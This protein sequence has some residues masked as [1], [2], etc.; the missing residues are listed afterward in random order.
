M[1]K[2]ETAK[3]VAFAIVT[4]FILWLRRPDSLLNAQFWAEDGGVFFREQVL[5]G[6][7]LIHIYAQGAVN[8]NLQVAIS[9]PANR[10]NFRQ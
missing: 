3:A 5:F 7:S 4:F 10:A 2:R 8:K 9:R 6:L 1:R